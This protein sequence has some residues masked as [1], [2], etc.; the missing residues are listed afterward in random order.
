M[1]RRTQ[2]KCRAANSRLYYRNSPR[3]RRIE[4]SIP[5]ENMKKAPLKA[6]RRLEP[7][8]SE[9]VYKEVWDRFYEQFRFRPSI[10]ARD[11]PGI[12]EPVPSVTYSLKAAFGSASNQHFGTCCDETNNKL[13]VAFRACTREQD[14]L[15][16]LIGNTNHS[17]STHIA[18]LKK[19]ISAS[20]RFPF[21]Q[22]ETITS[23][24]QK[25]SVSALLVIRGKKRFASSGSN[26]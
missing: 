7:T 11:W 8:L 22:T 26:L 3:A 14:R 13:L 2:R 21:F 20:G 1:R 15:Y 23:S 19:V 25:I 12:I 5:G 18:P 9:S 4:Y 16:A 24:S 6:W 17:G 10:D